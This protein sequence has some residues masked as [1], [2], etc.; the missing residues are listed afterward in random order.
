MEEYIFHLTHLFK[1]YE[2][3]TCFLAY[4]QQQYAITWLPV[5]TNLNLVAKVCDVKLDIYVVVSNLQN[6]LPA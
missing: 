4:V 2:I 5:I 1:L 3:S 6:F